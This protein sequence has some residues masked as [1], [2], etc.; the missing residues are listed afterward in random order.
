MLYS[1]GD[2]FQTTWVDNEP[3]GIGTYHYY[4]GSQYT[5]EW[6]IS[7]VKAIS[8]KLGD[9][10]KCLKH[11]KGLFEWPNGAFYEGNFENDKMEGFGTYMWPD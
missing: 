1:N 10:Q 8:N 3:V 9:F 5:G 7:K 11:G 2:A 6:K 4:D